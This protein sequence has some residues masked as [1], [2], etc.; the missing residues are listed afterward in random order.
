MSRAEAKGVSDW[1]SKVRSGIQYLETGKRVTKWET[2]RKYYHNQ[3]SDT[4]VTVNLIFALGRALVPQLYF[5]C[6]TILVEPNRKG[7]DQGARILE[8]ADTWLINHIGLKQQIKLGIT[9][10]FLTNIAV[11]KHG[12]HSIGTELPTN[13]LEERTPEQLILALQDYL[14]E[15]AAEQVNQE[16]EERIKYSYHDWVKPDSPWVLRVQPED[17]IVPKGCKDIY[18]APWCAF[19][20][21]RP[22][23]DFKADPVYSNTTHL[24]PNVTMNTK[25]D[26]ASP[27][28]YKQIEGDSEMVEAWEIWDK[29]EGKIIVVVEGHEKYLRND[30]HGMNIDG[31][32]VE[33]LQFNPVGWDFW[34]ESDVTQIQQQVIENNEVRTLEIKHMRAAVLKVLYDKNLISADQ[35]SKMESGDIGMVGVDGSPAAA[36]FQ[37][38][39]TMSKD[40]FDV[41]EVIRGDIR[42]VMNFS[43]NQLSEFSSGRKTA[44]EAAIV[45]QAVQLRGDERRDQVADL[46]GAMFQRKINPMIF[47]YWTEQRAMQVTS[48]GGWV[49]FTGPQIKGDYTV[50]AIA[51]STVPLTRVQRQMEAKEAFALFKGDPR[52]DQRRL[53]EWT[54]SQLGETLPTDILLDE[55]KYQQVMKQQMVQQ[56]L[57]SKMGGGGG[58]GSAP[59]SGVQKVRPPVSKPQN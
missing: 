3:Y 7:F 12:Y 5:K 14:G 11:F 21:L 58:N 45:Q 48:L 55:D 38:T 53:Y 23:E 41:G 30:K 42:E 13:A 17:F 39:P 2:A 43:R 15:Q 56:V 46:I 33:M 52:L 26:I 6:P 22:V 47:D 20:V 40:V 10:G 35:A 16:D 34:G 31:L 1:T 27:N 59:R 57:M 19:R 4:A 28:R 36:I 25:A 44:T 49:K 8:A 37:V 32:P 9:D 24:K 50:T 54:I 51:D 18:S 29:Q